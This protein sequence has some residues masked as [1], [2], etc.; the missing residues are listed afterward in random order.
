MI[1]FCRVEI[2]NNLSH[3]K[4]AGHDGSKDDER[5]KKK[6]KKKKT[7]TG[8]RKI[9]GMHQILKDKSNDFPNQTVPFTQARL[10]RIVTCKLHTEIIHIAI[11]D[12]SLNA[13]IFQTQTNP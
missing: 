13:T 7:R 3:Y 10:A 8:R 6:R 9:K 5:R 1:H 12:Y 11:G 4:E 2:G